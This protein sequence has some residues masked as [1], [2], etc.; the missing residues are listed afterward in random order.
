[1]VYASISKLSCAKISAG[2]TSSAT[3]SVYAYGSTYTEASSLLKALPFASSK[4]M[5]FLL[6]PFLDSF[7]GIKKTSHLDR[8]PIT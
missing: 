4:K 3:A 5:F 6:G 7:L 8:E 2:K 1:M